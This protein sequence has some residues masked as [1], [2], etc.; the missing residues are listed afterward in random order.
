MIRPGRSASIALAVCALVLA[1]TM[2]AAAAPTWTTPS[3]ASGTVAVG[4]TAGRPAEEMG[5]VLPH[6]TLEVLGPDGSPLP[7]GAVGEIRRR[8]PEQAT[9]YF[10]DPEATSR[11]FRD[12]WVHPGDRGRSPRTGA[13]SSPDA[14][15]PS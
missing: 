5:R 12:G 1:G 11:S 8:T 6:V 13:S 3:R 4:D 7:R 9:G 15:P 10:R 2:P 14:R